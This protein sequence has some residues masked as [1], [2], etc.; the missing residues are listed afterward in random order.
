MTYGEARDLSLQLIMQYSIA[1]TGI[2]ETYNN[3]Q[4]YLNR[5][6]GLINAAEMDLATT[7]KKIPAVIS[8]DELIYTE[9][10]GWRMY[11][12]PSDA[13]QRKSSG[14]LIPNREGWRRFNQVKDLGRGQILIPSSVPGD[15]LLEYYR[16]PA[17]LGPNPEDNVAL[18]NV[19]EAQDAIPYYVGAMLCI[20]DDAFLYASLYNT[21]QEKKSQMTE[22]VTTEPTTV[23][24]VFGFGSDWGSLY[25]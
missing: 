21:Y 25:V 1:G 11:T 23:E 13:W 10:S 5:I 18:D 4:D 12:L 8:L 16:Y 2:P 9:S 3:Q 7:V 20:Q 22:L 24:D 6:P 17:R 19:P 15:A 14:L